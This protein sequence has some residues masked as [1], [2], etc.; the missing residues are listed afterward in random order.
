[1]VAEARRQGTEI[2]N[3]PNDIEYVVGQSRRS[4][5]EQ[6]DKAK[7]SFAAEKDGQSGEASKEA[8][9]EQGNSEPMEGVEHTADASP[10]FVVDSNP[11]PVHI[12]QNKPDASFSKGKNK[13]NDKAKRRISGPD[14]QV[15]T[16]NEVPKD[17][18]K[19]KKVKMEK[20][21]QGASES[22]PSV[23]EDDISEEVDRRLKE[24]E[25]R[26]RRKAEKKRKRESGSSQMAGEGAADVPADQLQVEKREKKKHK[27][28]RKLEE[29]KQLELAASE[30]KKCKK[31]DKKKRSSTD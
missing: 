18:H 8:E 5:R 31:D 26:R 23:E 9:P 22:K 1:M 2:K 20:A 25:E 10:L 14:E 19:K 16:A 4:A 7:K 15:H 29:T 30:E 17:S 28:D 27:K 21:E 13:A 24:K 12:L 11:T 3:D 6:L